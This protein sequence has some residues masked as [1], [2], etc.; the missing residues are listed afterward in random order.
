MNAGIVI[1]GDEILSGKVRDENGPYL[2]GE[3]AELGTDVKRMEVVGD[4]LDAIGDSVLRCHKLCD[5]VFTSGGVGPTHD[6][7]T[8]MAIAKAFGVRVVRHPALETLLR[9]FYGDHITDAPLR[10]TELPEGATLMASENAKWPAVQFHNLYILPGVP[11]ILRKKFEAMRQRFVGVP[12]I[13]RRLTCEMDE[14]DLAAHLQAT[15]FAHPEVTIGSYPQFDRKPFCV[16]VT[17]QSRQ[18]S[19]VE[20]AT[21][22]LAAR[23]GPDIVV[24][25]A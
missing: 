10:M 4:D 7:L 2:I 24:A 5:H 16:L 11:S 12:W 8:L 13:L 25:R 14:G 3:L 21:R 18:E 23:L 22:D 6:D 1:I 15:L 20:A 17:L 9:G 19:T